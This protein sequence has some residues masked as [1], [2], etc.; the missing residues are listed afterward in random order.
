MYLPTG[1]LYTLYWAL[2]KN[3]IF[4]PI[5]KKVE[6][7]Q[8]NER[9]SIGFFS[10]QIGSQSWKEIEDLDQS[11]KSDKQINECIYQLENYTPCTHWALKNNFIFD[12]ICKKVKNY[13]KKNGLL[14]LILNLSKKQA[15][16]GF[17]PP[18]AM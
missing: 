2:K 8:R 10:R 1:K 3:S 13:K 14:F 16:K 6:T 18:S 12:P 7:K 9:Y 15:R 17:R 5:S 11:T 4:V